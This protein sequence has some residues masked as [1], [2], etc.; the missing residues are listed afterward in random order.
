[1]LLS[2]KHSTLAAVSPESAR[3]FAIPTENRSMCA[4]LG[5]HFWDGYTLVL[6]LGESLKHRTESEDGEQ[7]QCGKRGGL[8]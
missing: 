8:S 1:M 2:A 3:L 5:A 4:L 7:E 6:R